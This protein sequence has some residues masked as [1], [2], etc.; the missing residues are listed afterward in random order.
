MV[1]AVYDIAFWYRPKPAEELIALRLKPEL[2]AALLGVDACEYRNTEPTPAP[3][4]LAARMSATLRVA[5]NG[6]VG[7]VAAALIGDMTR[8]SNANFNGSSI[9]CSAPAAIRSA[10]G[11]VGVRFLAQEFGVSERHLRRVFRNAVGC[12][13]KT[14][15]RRARLTAAAIAA[16]A[17]DEPDWAQIALETGFHDQAHMIGEYRALIGQ[18]PGR[19]HRERRGGSV[20]S[21]T[22]ALA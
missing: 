3:R 19:N 1:C 21:N 13:P 17:S 16:D 18:T 11:R 4:R 20:F 5:E 6:G 8:A 22:A 15:A 14:Y 12:S 9:A 7:E 10:Q 2:S